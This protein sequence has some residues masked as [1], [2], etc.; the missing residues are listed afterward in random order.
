MNTQIIT[1]VI[2]NVMIHSTCDLIHDFDF[3]IRFDSIHDF[4]FF[5]T[6]Y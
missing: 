2:R 4:S 1:K 6:N 5:K 3:T